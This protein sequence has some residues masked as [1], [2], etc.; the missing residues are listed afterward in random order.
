MTTM[1]FTTATG[2]DAEASYQAG[3]LDGEL[4]AVSQLPAEMHTV[5]ASW[6][7]LHDPMWAAG[8]TD[9]FIHATTLNGLNQQPV[10]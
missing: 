4:D 7:D 8:Y 9:G 5:R 3:F 2:Y 6:G 1:T 10:A